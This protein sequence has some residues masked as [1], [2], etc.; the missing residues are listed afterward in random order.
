VRKGGNRVRV[1]AQLIDASSGTHVWAERYERDLSDIF[2]VQDE[3]AASVA[4]VIEPALAEAEQQRALR[5]PPERM[6]AWE[7]YQRGLWHFNKYG[8]EENRTAL[9]F[10][11]RAIE[12]DPQFAPGH[13]GY[14][15]ALQWDTWHYSSRPFSEVQG[16]PLEEA[17]IAVSLDDKDA[18]AH[19]VLAHMR[20]WGS[21]WEAAI[22]QAQTAFALN[23]NSAFVISMLGCVLG[24]GGY[25]EE[26]LVRLQQA[27]R[28]SPHDPLIWLWT[29][30]TAMM[31]FYSRKFD[32]ATKTL[33]ELIR[34]RPGFIQ[35]QVILASSL[36]HSG[37]IEEAR[38][39]LKRARA[40]ARDTRY[41][42]KPPWTRPEDYALRLEG[43]RL[44]ELSE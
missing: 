34:L 31:Q 11:R 8:A 5:K 23:P 2:A 6:D 16:V 28:A 13:H 25:R 17:Q 18:M 9:T 35:G 24:F 21:E 20:L 43:I 15:L 29:M 27:I 3:M 44:A 42:K 40:K 4:G 19:A 10:F 26:A 1:T 41:E 22:A 7:A 12:L 14:A 37:R 32:A 33:Q 38:E 39:V 30:W 36:A